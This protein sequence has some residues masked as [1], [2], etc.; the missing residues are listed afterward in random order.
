MA[1]H[2]ITTVDHPAPVILAGG[3]GVRP[4]RMM[5][6]LPKPLLPLVDGPVIDVL[7]RQ[8]RMQG[9]RR[10]TLAVGHMADLIRAYCGDGTRYDLTLEYVEEDE[11]LG[12]VGPLALLPP[13]RLARSLLVM[14]G[15]LLTSLRFADL[16]A[17]H[18]RCGSIAT[19]A[20]AHRPIRIEFGMLGLGPEGGSELP[21]VTSYREKPEIPATLSMGAYVF[22]PEV[23]E[24]IDAGRP[25]DLPDL[26]DRLMA[27]GQRVSAYP[28]DGCW[29]DI[30]RHSDHQTAI[31]D[32]RR[33][34]A[35]LFPTIVVAS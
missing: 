34:R 33:V 3:R 9:W 26:V 17:A 8:L 27:D 5:S 23:L 10:A 1:D 4:S 18:E 14:N 22:R 28:Y 21:R 20:V 29:L 31:E 6:A 12:T 13:E 15:D 35:E 16:I 2:Q 30:G 19:I 7:L 11:P 25:L 24:Y 32:F